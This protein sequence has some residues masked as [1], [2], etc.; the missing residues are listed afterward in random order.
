MRTLFICFL[1]GA[2][3]WLIQQGPSPFNEP[4]SYLGVLI[5]LPVLGARVAASLRAAP[6]LGA[7]AAGLLMGPMGL[8]SNRALGGLAP[9]EE[10]AMAWVGLYLGTTLAPAVLSDRRLILTASSSA[11]GALLLTSVTLVVLYSA[12]PREALGLGLIA[13]LGAPIFTHYVRPI[14][15]EAFPLSLLATAL[16]L[17]ALGLVEVLDWQA[18]LPLS[19]LL[20][21]LVLWGAGIE[22]TYQASLRIRTDP[23]RFLLFAGLALLVVV[24]S[25]ALHV[26]AL[27]LS[28][29][30]G[31]ALSLR[32]GARRRTFAPL[33]ATAELAL[34]VVVGGF[35]ARLDVLG[36]L[37]LSASQW[38]F[39][40]LYAATMV[41]GKVAG[42]LLANRSSDA[43]LR[44]WSPLLLQ[45]IIAGTL[46]PL[47]L[48][49]RMGLAAAGAAPLQAGL[50]LLCGIGI[51]LFL[52]PIQSLVNRL[53]RTRVQTAPRR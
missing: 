21:T 35:A 40:L 39:L 43:P 46:F 9:F 11:L 48:P 47:A 6:Y 31:L 53:M 36:L 37:G 42:C 45:G 16:G 38:Q 49:A 22:A 32:F 23:G 52:W 28:A 20:T 34:P 14:R 26:H 30:T 2:L 12:T 41:A 33:S 29:L 13:A 1:L 15:W 24:A 19:A 8:L 7:L 50:I 3:A 4:V 44:N 18:S 17:A 25:H 51:P 10:L 27:F 5:V